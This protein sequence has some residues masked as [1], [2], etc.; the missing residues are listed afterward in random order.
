[1]DLLGY[2]GIIDL[3]ISREA[4][5]E[6]AVL[7]FRRRKRHRMQLLNDIESDLSKVRENRDFLVEDASLW[8][9]DSGFK[10]NFSTQET[11]RLIREP[12]MKLLWT[13]G[14][15]FSQATPKFAFI[16]WFA[17]LNRL[18]TLDR[19]AKWSIGVDTTCVLC[20]NAE[21]SRDH[22]FF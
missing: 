20:K 6:E 22:L 2:R 5:V 7:C 19:V 8:R 15:W 17:T 18:S 4:T 10:N 16:T 11:W 21:E 12:K 13:R 9:R 1:M 14:V 3:G